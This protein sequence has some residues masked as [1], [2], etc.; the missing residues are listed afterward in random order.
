MT[1]RLYH[2]PLDAPSRRVR[3]ALAEKNVACEFLVQKPWDLTGPF[4]AL[5]A[6]GEVPVLVCEDGKERE[7][8]VDAQAICEF[9]EETQSGETLLGKDPLARSEVRRLIAW[10]DRKFANEVTAFLVGEKAIKRLQGAGEP[11]SLKIHSGCQ[12]IRAHLNY[13]VWLAERRNWLAGPSISLADLAAGA[14]F[15]VVD[16]MGDVPWNDFP[17]AKEWYARLKSRPSFRGLLGDHVAGFPPPRHYADLD[18]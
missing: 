6:A 10:F 14:H 13:V 5:N 7:V 12:N 3:L 11:D 15:S 17:L 1:Y 9:L 4:A 16:Y 2:H 8:I 18:F